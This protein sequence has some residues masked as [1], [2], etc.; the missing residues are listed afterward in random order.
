MLLFAAC[1]GEFS[2]PTVLFLLL[3]LY[4]ALLLRVR[5]GLAALS[6]QNPVNS[7]GSVAA[8]PVYAGT[9]F[10]SNPAL[11]DLWFPRGRDL[12]NDVLCPPS[13]SRPYRLSML[14]VV[15]L[16][17]PTFINLWD[18]SSLCLRP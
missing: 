7:D 1:V 2:F 6:S 11:M 15:V 18:C 10:R 9:T 13:I 16:K 12:H 4:F 14:H 3:T 17:C 8:V 5:S